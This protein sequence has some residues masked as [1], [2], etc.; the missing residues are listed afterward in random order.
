MIRR[1]LAS[2]AIC[3]ALS[4]GVALAHAEQRSLV[5]NEKFPYPAVEAGSITRLRSACTQQSEDARWACL[6][7]IAAVLDT[8]E[9][10]VRRHP[11]LAAYCGMTR[12]GP[13]RARRQA[14][15]FCQK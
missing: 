7:T 9:I 10:M 6:L 13:E 1:F 5:T 3:L 2:T 15:A 12:P 4:L 8:H 11:D 14:R